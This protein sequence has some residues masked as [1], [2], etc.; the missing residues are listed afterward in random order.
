MEFSGDVDTQKKT[1]RHRKPA[2]PYKSAPS[3]SSDEEEGTLLRNHL[4]GSDSSAA[5]VK[6]DK[7]SL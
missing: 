3:S 1:Q 5:T 4:L 6:M 7:G 2:D